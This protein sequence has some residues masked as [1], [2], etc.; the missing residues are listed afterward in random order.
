MVSRRLAKK[1]S[2]ATT[3]APTRCTVSAAKTASMPRSVP[4]RKTVILR[5]SA[6]GRLD[7]LHLV[8]EVRTVRVHE[9]T[10][11]AQPG[12]QLVQQLEPFSVGLGSE[13]RDSGYIAARPV[14][15]GDQAASD[16]ITRR[17]RPSSRTVEAGDQAASDRIGGRRRGAPRAPCLHRPELR[18]RREGARS[19]PLLVRRCHPI[20]TRSN[21]R[22]PAA[23]PWR[24]WPG[25][26]RAARAWFR[27][28]PSARSAPCHSFP[29]APDTAGR[30]GRP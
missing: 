30:C 13:G 27:G 19:A 7:I 15:A 28:R 18:P 4:A 14:E 3:I 29:S 2:A 10:D 11:H 9:H 26:P 1:G 17:P 20:G 12:H 23:Q 8:L 5:P 21:G 25:R 22:S 16:R 6:R 24:L